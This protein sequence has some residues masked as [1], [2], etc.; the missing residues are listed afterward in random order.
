M[1]QLPDPPLAANRSRKRAVPPEVAPV[2]QR[3]RLD[4]AEQELSDLECP[5]SS[6]KTMASILSVLAA[7]LAQEVIAYRGRPATVTADRM[8]ADIDDHIERVL[9]QAYEVERKI[10]ELAKQYYYPSGTGED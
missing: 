5:I 7:S 6:A 2:D 10:N 8:A 1:L 4:A 3:S 9:F